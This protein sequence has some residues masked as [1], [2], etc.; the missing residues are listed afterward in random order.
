AGL[1][2]HRV[3]VPGGE[4]D[5]LAFAG[6][7]DLLD[8]GGLEPPFLEHFVVPGFRQLHIVALADAL[9]TPRE[10]LA[11]AA[12]R[13]EQRR[14]DDARADVDTDADG[15]VL[16]SVPAVIVWIPRCRLAM[17]FAPVASPPWRRGPCSALTSSPPYLP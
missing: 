12:F 3:E 16:A 15:H 8:V 7:G 6:C 17:P 5:V 13:L 14:L 9:D 11:L 1:R 2:G 4:F 10:P